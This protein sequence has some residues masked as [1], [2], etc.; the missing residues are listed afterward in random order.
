MPRDISRIIAKGA[1]LV[2]TAAFAIYVQSRP[3][4]TTDHATLTAWLYYSAIACFVYLALSFLLRW[5][6]CQLIFGVHLSE[7]SVAPTVAADGEI[8]KNIYDLQNQ[9][10]VERK[11]ALAERKAREKSEQEL[12]ELRWLSLSSPLQMDALHLSHDII[13]YLREFEPKPPLL[14]PGSAEGRQRVYER[15]DWAT[16]LIAGYQRRFENRDR[17]I[18]LKFKESGVGVRIG[19][20]PVYAEEKLYQWAEELIAL[21]Y[22]VDGIT[23]SVG[24]FQ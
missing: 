15:A 8:Q 11:E 4:W 6:W 13:K 3:T 20:A 12:A 10:Q 17:E 16:R 19:T 22:K 1:G 7:T 5:K 23:L 21:A 2:I 14:D 18:S 24:G 9:L